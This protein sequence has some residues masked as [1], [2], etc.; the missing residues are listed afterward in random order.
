M[1]YRYREYLLKNSPFFFKVSV[2][3]TNQRENGLTD[4][5]QPE[6]IHSVFWEKGKM[7]FSALNRINILKASDK[8]K[9]AQSIINEWRL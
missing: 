4:D 1:V 2:M 3:T 5:Q 6:N 7:A 8:N 9:D